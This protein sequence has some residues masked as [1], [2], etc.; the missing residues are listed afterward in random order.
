MATKK[1]VRKNT[2]RGNNE[3]SIYQKPNGKWVAMITIGYDEQGKRIRQSFQGDSRAEV[4]R[5]VNEITAERTSGGPVRISNE[6]LEVSMMEWL[7][8]F[9]RATVSSRTFDRCLGNTKIHI[10]PALGR[11]KVVNITPTRVQNALNNMLFKGYALASVRKIKFLLNQFFAYAKQTGLITKNPME[12]CVVKATEAHRETKVEKYKA[13]PERLR[14]YFLE[15]IKKSEVLYP[16]CMV[17]L[18]AGLRIGEVLALKWKDVDLILDVITVDNAVT[19]DM[20]FDDEGRVIQHRTI[21]SDTKTAA[22]VREVPIPPILKE[23]LQEWKRIRTGRQVATRKSFIGPDDLVFSTNAGELRSY[24]GTRR[25][26][27]KL[28]K[29]NGLEKYHFHFHS[30]RHTY[31]TMLW[32]SSENPKVIQML[33]G[34]KD[35]T[36]TIK[37][38]NS[39][40]RSYFKQ[41][42]D[43][44]ET[45]FRQTTQ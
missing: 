28:M 5:R 38:Y 22:S 11:F 1:T 27:D 31:S 44:L 43:K 23:C 7:N 35:V 14:P 21:I 12:Y 20:T 41:A 40:D 42:T 13:I 15:V 17:Q 8:T 34:H 36:T 6:C 25:M 29:K 39:V 32:E 4:V 24:H 45:K 2:R 18:F 3:G 10:L 19:V 33:L 26:F 16:I 9:K 37:T 30:L